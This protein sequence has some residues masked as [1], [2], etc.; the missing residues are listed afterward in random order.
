MRRRTNPRQNPRR[1]SKNSTFV[2]YFPAREGKRERER[3]KVNRLK[4]LNEERPR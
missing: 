3:D 1:C 2:E 4:K